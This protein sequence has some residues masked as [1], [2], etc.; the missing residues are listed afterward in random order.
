MGD[1]RGRFPTPD[2]LICLAGVAPSTR[3]SG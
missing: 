3:Q 1:A 2:S